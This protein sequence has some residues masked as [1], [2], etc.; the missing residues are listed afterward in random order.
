ME[1][2]RP[3]TNPQKLH[4]ETP[5]ATPDDSR[6]DVSSPVGVFVYGTLQQGEQREGA[7][8]RTPRSRQRA[9]VRGI[10]FDLGPYPALLPGNDLVEGEFWEIAPADMPATLEVLDCIEGYNQGGENLYQRQ[11]I[12][13]HLET[14][15]V[16]AAHV[17]FLAQSDRIHR[18]DKV[19]AGPGGIHL[20]R[21]GPGTANPPLHE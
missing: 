18:M 1:S 9:T 4:Q 11:V 14:G 8:P 12:S 7:W 5:M 20:W 2:A 16:V 21:R 3:L 13:C 19:T 15:K 6:D 10:L 17:Y